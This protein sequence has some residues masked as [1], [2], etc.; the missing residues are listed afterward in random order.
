MAFYTG[1]R[2]DNYF[3]GTPDDDT[4]LGAGGNDDA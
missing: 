2:F 3:L 1:N 4:A